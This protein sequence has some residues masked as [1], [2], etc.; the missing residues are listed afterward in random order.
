MV[1]SQLSQKHREVAGIDGASGESNS[2]QAVRNAPGCK[3]LSVRVLGVIS[4]L[5]D[6]G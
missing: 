6:D 3:M 1:S 5:C 2:R 4:R